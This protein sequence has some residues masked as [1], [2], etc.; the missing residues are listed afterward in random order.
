M[1]LMVISICLQLD[2]TGADCRRR[3]QGPYLTPMECRTRI[4][5]QHDAILALAEELGA[6]VLFINVSCE[7]GRDG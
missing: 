3:S 1:W 5:G 7:K 4:E 6:K 2:A